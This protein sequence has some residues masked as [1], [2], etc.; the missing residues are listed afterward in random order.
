MKIS[1]AIAGLLLLLGALH[2]DRGEAQSSGGSSGPDLSKYKKPEWREFVENAQIE[3]ALEDTP[4]R[5]H[6]VLLQ[7]ET[8][9]PNKRTGEGFF[10]DTRFYI[11]DTDA[12]KLWRYSSGRRLLPKHCLGN[13]EKTCFF[14]I[15]EV[16]IRWG[17][18]WNISDDL[19]LS[20]NERINRIT[21]QYLATKYTYLNGKLTPDSPTTI[22]GSCKKIEAAPRF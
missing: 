3:R 7:C 10:E 5:E 19:R 14:T 4:P 20:S 18:E 21:G 22:A 11:L 16:A 15:S 17:S 8:R 6:E 9:I 13:P 2:I 12:Q 1:S